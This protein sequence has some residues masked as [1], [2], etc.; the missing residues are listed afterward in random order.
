MAILTVAQIKKVGFK[1]IG[2]NVRISDK[3]SI[4]G[5]EHIEIGDNVR[6]DDFCVL[7][8]GKQGIKIGSH[9]H[10]AVHSSII[11]QGEVI[12]SD[13]ANI[14]SRVSIYSSNDDYSGLSMTSPVID[15]KYTNV[16]HDKVFIGKHVIVGSGSVVLPGSTINHGAAIGA[17]SMVKAELDEFTIYAGCP[18]RKIKERKRDILD[19]EI[20]FL[21]SYHKDTR[22]S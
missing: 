15:N 4:Y 18:L 3:A 7:S 20:E 10:I 22:R 11:G 12:I 17:L 9:I 14:S 1:N 8:A 2:L 21:K 16:K 5:A 13:F 6:V 19:L